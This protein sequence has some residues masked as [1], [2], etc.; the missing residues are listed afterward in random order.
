MK[1]L[2]CAVGRGTQLP[3]RGVWDAE[4]WPCQNNYP[5]AHSC[6]VA[7]KMWLVCRAGEL[8]LLRC[9]VR[10]QGL[11][12]VGSAATRFFLVCMARP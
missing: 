9:N 5:S 12:D 11:V 8:V 1:L 3:E 6:S 10:W 7:S 2:G 4:L